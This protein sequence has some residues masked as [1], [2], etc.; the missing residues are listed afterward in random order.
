MMASN[1]LR[2]GKIKEKKRKM[3]SDGHRL[4]IHKLF[5]GVKIRKAKQKES[6]K[7]N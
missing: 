4:K 3:L 2:R 6:K 5:Y 7:A 1:K